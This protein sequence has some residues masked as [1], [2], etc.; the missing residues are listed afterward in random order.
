MRIYR[1]LLVHDD[2]DFLDVA[3]RW[4]GRRGFLIIG[5][6]T[7]PEAILAIER[8]PLDVAVVDCGLG[9]VKSWRLVR[10][11]KTLEPS[12]SIVVLGGASGNTVLQPGTAE[13]AE[14]IATPVNLTELE[15]SVHRVLGM[16]TKLPERCKAG[17]TAFLQ[18]LSCN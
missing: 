17:R 13:I 16:E 12:R 7:A 5:C 1:L 11:L 15:A 14:F 4:L 2:D 6:E 3:S 10:H 9:D 18:L 8:L